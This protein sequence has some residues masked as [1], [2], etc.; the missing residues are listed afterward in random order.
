MKV[1][2]VGG[3]GGFGATISRHLDLEGHRV[4]AVGRSKAP[5]IRL[6]GQNPRIQFVAADRETIDP[7]F[8]RSRGIEAVVDASGPFQGRDVGLVR[9]AIFAG[10]HYVDI[11]DD[12]S[13]IQSVEA[14]STEARAAGIVVV[15]GASSTPGLSG[16]VVAQCIDGMERVDTVDIAISASNQ[17]TFGEAVLG[18]VMDRAGAPFRPGDE[19]QMTDFK[20]I[21]MKVRSVP[22]M[23][24]SILRCDSPDAEQLAGVFGENVRVRFWAGGEA[25]WQNRSM[26]IIAWLVG[27]R[28][29]SSGSRMLPLARL[30]RRLSSGRGSGRSGM[31]VR[32][33][34]SDAGRRVTR[35]WTLIA[36]N[37][38]GPLIPAMG[39]PCVIAAIADG[40]LKPGVSRAS[41]IMDIQGVV[42][43]MPKGS[44]RHQM[45]GTILDPL[46]AR[47]MGDDFR[48]L[49]PAIV[50]AHSFG[51]KHL[52]GLARIDGPEGL[53]ARLVAKAF[54][55]PAA[56][57]EVPV[58][59]HFNR[60]AHG[61]TWTRTFGGRSFSSRL[62]QRGDRLQ[63]RFGPFRFLFRLAQRDGGIAMLPLGWSFMG[64]PLPKRLQPDGVATERG[65]LGAFI[66][67]VPINV[68]LVGRVVHYRGHLRPA[69]P[70]QV[71]RD[72]AS[73]ITGKASMHD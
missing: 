70:P 34:G 29:L 35:T 3:T 19:R 14:L 40:A 52:V 65:S 55:F 24:R 13:F 26:Q 7:V 62:E 48:L 20:R 72:L 43:R 69:A 11:S 16:A 47:I 9:T 39:V 59:V 32:A 53:V 54:G 50:E 8:I 73:M 71:R 28:I 1:L 64:I 68:P 2:V 6:M 18:A 15:S 45:R 17:A 42:G 5:G 33:T 12:G 36:E 67:D 38:H 27:K 60:D 10:V 4:V 22:G 30:A 57:D 46:Y 49:H 58:S 61:E 21:T 44:V 51:V 31:K 63:E 56:G 41:T 66:F 25:D 23:T 37:G